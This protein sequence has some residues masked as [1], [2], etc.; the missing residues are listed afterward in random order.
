VTPDQVWGW[1]PKQEARSITRSEDHQVRSRDEMCHSVL[2]RSNPSGSTSTPAHPPEQGRQAAEE[3]IHVIATPGPQSAKTLK[4][5]KA[6]KIHPVH[7]GILTT[8]QSCHA[9]SDLGSFPPEVARRALPHLDSK[10][11]D[12]GVG[13]GTSRI[14]GHRRRARSVGPTGARSVPAWRRCP[15]DRC[16]RDPPRWCDLAR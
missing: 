14:A 5:L 8:L 12:E 7:L 9:R 2:L 15:L 4:A 16:Q 13:S 11:V 1:S 6:N 3:G 10:R